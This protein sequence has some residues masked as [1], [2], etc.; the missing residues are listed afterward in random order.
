VADG[1]V[2]EL[3]AGAAGPTASRKSIANCASAA[4]AQESKMAQFHFRSR[5]MNKAE[6]RV[7]SLVIQITRSFLSKILRIF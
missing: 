7:H 1:F 3:H 4:K 6:S 2:R 5:Q